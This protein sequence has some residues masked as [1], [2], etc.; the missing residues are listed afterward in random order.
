MKTTKKTYIIPSIDI[1][2]LKTEYQLLVGSDGLKT[3]D[4]RHNP[5][6]T[7]VFIE[8]EDEIL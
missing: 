1:I 4:E 6:S 7:D 8:T 3:Y 2:M 5:E